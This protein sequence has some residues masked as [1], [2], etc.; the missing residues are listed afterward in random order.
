MVALKYIR[1][2]PLGELLVRSGI[3]TSEQL[4]QAREAKHGLPLTQTLVALGFA[5]EADIAKA[6]AKQLGL[7]FV[8][9]ATYEIDPQA[10]SLVPDSFAQRHLV[11]PIGFEGE[12][13]VVAMA[14][15]ANIIATDDL[16]IMTGYEIIPMVATES[17]LRAAISKYC[18]TDQMLEEAV[19]SVGEEAAELTPEEE[20]KEAEEAPIVKL[21]N[22]ILTDAVRERANDIHIEPQEKEI[23]IRYRIDGVLQEKMRSPKK[24][25]PGIT[26]RIKIMARLDISQRRMPQDGRFGLTIDKKPIDFRVATLP[27]IYGEKIALRVLEKESIMIHLDDL[28]FLP[29]ALERFQSAFNKP[30]GA[31]LVTGPTGSGKT[32]TLY[33]ALSILN[34]KE[35]NLITVEEPVEYRLPSVNQVQVN[36]RTGLTFASALR[37]ILRHDPDIVMIGEVRDK[38]T[39]IIAIEAA[40]TGHLVLTTLHTNDAPSALTRLTEMGIEPFLTSSAIDCIVAQRLA[41]RLCLNCRKPYKPSRKALLEIGFPLDDNNV[42]TLYKAVGCKMCSNTGY[43]G[44]IG[45]FEVLL[46]TEQIE[47]LI[48]NKATTDEIAKVAR[49]EG[50]RPLR[51]DGYEKVKQGITTIEEVMRV[52]L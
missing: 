21:V 43:R 26:S 29:D 22:M 6:L 39:A 15:P 32:T 18:M 14:D 7:P 5:K 12:K 16:H 50:M 9:L 41:R 23:R 46:V 10:V 28:G 17:D 11:L 27:T 2:E 1:G 34:S 44:R 37:S 8:E 33:A 30:Y 38:E 13:L 24:L 40:L 36:P 42:P 19:E 25:Q 35:K 20:E 4:K 45:L 3:I 31:I 51:F 52:T 48:V 47:R 49:E